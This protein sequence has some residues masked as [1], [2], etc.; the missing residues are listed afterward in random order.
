M[1]KV[2]FHLYLVIFLIIL[3]SVILA[4]GLKGTLGFISGFLLALLYV[5]AEGGK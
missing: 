1:K 3:I 2:Q 5:G 4:L